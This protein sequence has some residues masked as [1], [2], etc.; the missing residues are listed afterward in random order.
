MSKT[1][2]RIQR[3]VHIMLR[4]ITFALVMA[5]ALGSA[6]LVPAPASALRQ[7]WAASTSGISQGTVSELVALAQSRRAGG[8][9]VA[10]SI[11]RHPA[12]SNRPGLPTHPAGSAQARPCPYP[13]LAS[14]P[15]SSLAESA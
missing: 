15:V 11:D 4:K 3:G 2:I 10:G 14:Q 1:R 12:R 5:I 8:L 9:P 13:W 7:Y 6:A